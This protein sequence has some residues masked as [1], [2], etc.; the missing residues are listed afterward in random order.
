M[1]KIISFG[2]FLRWKFMAG[3]VGIEPTAAIKNNYR[4]RI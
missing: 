3:G 2:G 4:P 1:S